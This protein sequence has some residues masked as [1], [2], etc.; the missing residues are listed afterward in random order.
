[1]DISDIRRK[2]LADLVQ[3]IGSQ[4]KAGQLFGISES[5]M[6]Q[7]KNGMKDIGNDQA[8]RIETASGIERG[9]MDQVHEGARASAIRIPSTAPASTDKKDVVCWV[10][11]QLAPELQDN[12]VAYVLKMGATAMTAPTSG[13]VATE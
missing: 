6:S 2:N 10:M 7:Y 13:T 12:I 9:W 1:M 8:R 4:R 5:L 3:R 11:D